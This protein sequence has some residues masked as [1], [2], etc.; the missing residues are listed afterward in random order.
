MVNQPHDDMELTTEKELYALIVTSQ[1]ESNFD[2]DKILNDKAKKRMFTK[3]NVKTLIKNVI[4]NA[5]VAAMLLQTLDDNIVTNC[6]YKPK[7]LIKKEFPYDSEDEEYHPDKMFEEK[8]DEYDDDEFKLSGLNKSLDTE[9]DISD[10]KTVVV[11]NIMETIGMRTA[12]ENNEWM[13]FLSEFTKPLES[14]RNDDGEDD[15]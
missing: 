5:D 10:N 1:M 12:C 4:T 9:N 2:I 11:V 3:T 8:E 15:P 14:V 13:E 6:L 7:S